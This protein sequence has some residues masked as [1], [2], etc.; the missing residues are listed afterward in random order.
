MKQIFDFLRK[1]SGGTL[2]QKQ[3]DAANRLIATATDVSVADMLGIEIDQMAISPFGVDL[4]CSFEG[5]RL[6]AYDDGVGVWT[7]GFGTTVYPNGIKV[8]KGDTC[9]EAQAKT[10]MAHDLKKFEATVNKAVTLQL[11]QNQF[12][13]LVSLAYNIGASAFSQSTLVKKLN[14]HDIRGAADQFDVWVNAGGKRMQ[15]LVN[16][17]SKEKQLFLK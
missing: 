14:A 12:D 11:N 10:Y 3:V 7:I 16:R 8:K 17:R 13:A 6:T 1:I 4:I 15:G 9:T 2:T 5:K